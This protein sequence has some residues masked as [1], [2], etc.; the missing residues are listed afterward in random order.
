MAIPQGFSYLAGHLDLRRQHS[1]LAAV[2]AVV[3]HSPLY[4]PTMP[5][6]GK[7]LSVSMTN[8]GPLGWLTDKAG[9]YRYQSTHPVTGLAWPPIPAELLRVWDELAAY[10]APPEAC[11]INYYTR[12]SRLGSHIDADEAD[13][14]APVLSISLGDDALFHVGGL[15]RGAPKER[16]VLRSGDVVVL[17]GAAR[18]AYHGVDRVHPGTSNL[19][20]EGGRINL[21]LRRV[22][23]PS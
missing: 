22:N 6:T 9:G 8:C 12:A 15:R 10:T 11:L 5:R 17:G 13:T 14:A 21:T 23:S 4:T 19:L 7:P 2:R 18:L 20:A 3:A 16:I 1:I